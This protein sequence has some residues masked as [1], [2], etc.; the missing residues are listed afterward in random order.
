MDTQSRDGSTFK[1]QSVIEV[2][3]R[4]DAI[5]RQTDQ[6]PHWKAVCQNNDTDCVATAQLILTYQRLLESKESVSDSQLQQISRQLHEKNIYLSPPPEASLNVST[7]ISS[8]QA[9]QVANPFLTEENL[10]V[11]DLSCPVARSSETIIAYSDL[12]TTQLP[13]S[14]LVQ[15][16]D[17]PIRVDAQNGTAQ[18]WFISEERDF[19]LDAASQTLQVN[20]KSFQWDGEKITVGKG[21]IFIDKDL[22]SQLM[23]L[24]FKLSLGELTAV[25]TPREKLP[26]EK[27]YARENDRLALGNRESMGL[28]YPLEKDSYGLV[29]FPRMDFEFR[30]GLRP[31]E[32]TLDSQ[33]SVIAE[34]DLGFM[35]AE[36]YFAGD[37]DDWGDSARLTLNRIDLNSELLGPLHA[38]QIY[39]GDIT[40]TSIPILGGGGNEL[41]VSISNSDINRTSDFDTTRFEGNVQSG[42]DVEIYRNGTLVGS[43]LADSDGKYIFED[44]PVFYGKNAFQV[45]GYG[46]QGQKQVLEEDEIRIGSDMVVPEKLNY[47]LSVSQQDSSFLGLEEDTSYDESARFTGKVELGLNKSITGTAGISSVDNGD[48]RHTYLQTGLRSAFNSWYGQADYVLDP[49]GGSALSTQAQTS[50]W[51]QNFKFKQEFFSDFNRS[52]QSRN[53]FSLSGRTE[54]LP[55][56]S[57]LSYRFSN[58]YSIYSDGD[59]KAEFGTRLAT[60]LGKVSLSNS[61]KLDYFYDDEG[62][63]TGTLDASGNLLGARLRGSM[64]YTLGNEDR[65]DQYSL[66]STWKLASNLDAGASIVKYNDTEQRDVTTA[67][68]L[69]WDAG[70]FILSPSLSYDTE[71]GTEAY[72]GLTF[73]LGKKTASNRLAMRSEEI[74]GKGAATAFVYHDE[75]NNQIFDGADQPIPG[76]GIR[77]RQSNLDAT[78]NEQGM[79]DF[80]SMRAYKPVDVEL[81]TDSLQDPY[82]QPAVQGKAI[83]PRPGV[84]KIVELPVITTGEIDGNIYLQDRFGNKEPLSRI[85][86][87]IYNEEGEWIQATRSEYDG[88]YLFQGVPPGEYLLKVRENDLFRLDLKS[89]EGQPV[90]IGND[91]TISSGNTIILRPNAVIDNTTKQATSQPQP[92]QTGIDFKAIEKQIVIDPLR[93]ESHFNF[94]SP[95]TLSVSS[96]PLEIARGRGEEGNSSNMEIGSLRIQ[97]GGARQDEKS[98]SIVLIQSLLVSE[99]NSDRKKTISSLLSHPTANVSIAPLKVVEREEVTTKPAQLGQQSGKGRQKF[100]TAIFSNPG[101]SVVDNRGGSVR[102]K[103]GTVVYSNPRSSMADNSGGTPGYSPQFTFSEDSPIQ[104]RTSTTR[105]NNTGGEG[106]KEKVEFRY[107]LAEGF[108]K[109]PTPTRVTSRFD[110]QKQVKAAVSSNIQAEDN[111]KKTEL[112]SQKKKGLSR[113]WQPIDSFTAIGQPIHLLSPIDNLLADSGQSKRLAKE[114]MTPAD[115]RRLD[116]IIF[117]ANST[118]ETEQL[119]MNHIEKESEKTALAN[120]ARIARMYASMQK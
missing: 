78:T 81:D 38:S 57:R 63:L 74:T 109:A 69:S 95:K 87:E 27:V 91:G 43:M 13:L 70:A 79:A 60:T 32:S 64:K 39:V 22:L 12:L 104:Q 41:G 75:N 115:A 49:E 116:A 8:P 119:A 44:I 61:T 35:G 108:R 36:A 62:P 47:S 7:P 24:D 110:Q 56:L 4:A 51:G 117:Q 102:Q 31:G 107:P 66:R 82:W 45:I 2:V 105:I 23:P 100:G 16:L 11:L 93:I 1:F 9:F 20:G 19:R 96:S 68:N 94:H 21:D 10:L 86:L 37:S 71:R 15:I 28:K 50:L 54:D 98:G 114:T 14:E 67:L 65:L 33:Y 84:N 97:Q 48:S 3:E 42:W 80:S 46:P 99:N 40:P 118:Q 34:G 58:K 113:R 112:I 88:F 106:R 17:F 103:F 83:T 92:N 85:G 72:V 55:V 5:M 89:E 30:N 76:A 77:T 6:Y 26:I 18:G 120:R 25:I 29:S 73:S 59:Q 53:T 52:L 101:S 111:R 90:T